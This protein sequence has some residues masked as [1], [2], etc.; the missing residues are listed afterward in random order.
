MTPWTHS[1]CKL[2][3]YEMHPDQDLPRIVDI[4]TRDTC[5]RCGLWT[6]AGLYIQTEPDSFPFCADQ[7]HQWRTKYKWID[8]RTG[9]RVSITCCD[10]VMY[11]QQFIAAMRARDRRGGRPDLH[12]LIPHLAIAI[13]Q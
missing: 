3:W 4:G 10:S 9:E 6:T 5:C 8:R 12:E 13:D 11:A 7:R 2:C 1:I